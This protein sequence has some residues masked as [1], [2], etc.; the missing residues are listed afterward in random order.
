MENKKKKKNSHAFLIIIILVAA[1]L[2][3]LP[4]LISLRKQQSEI[5]EIRSAA[6]E[7]RTFTTSLSGAGTLTN[8]ESTAVMI[9]DGV[10]LTGYL[11]KN[12]DTI[13]A[14]TAVA[15]VDPVSV[16]D[17]ISDVKDALTELEEQIEEAQQDTET[18]TIT[19]ELDGRV[20]KLFVSAGSDVKDAMVDSGALVLISLDGLMAV[21]LSTDLDL[22][23]GDKVSVTVDGAAYEG[24]VETV[25]KGKATVTLTDDGPAYGSDAEVFTESGISIGTGKVYIHSCWKLSAYSGTVSSVYVSEGEEVEAD[26]SILDLEGVDTTAKYNVLTAEHRVYEEIMTELFALY[27]DNTVYADADGMVSGLD[28]DLL[29]SCRVEEPAADGAGNG[30]TLGM[31][32]GT[33]AGGTL[34]MSNDAAA[35]GTLGMSNDTTA[36]A[37]G[38]TVLLSL[39]PGGSDSSVYLHQ[40]GQVTEVGESGISL[41]LNPALQSVSDYSSLSGVDLSNMT[42]SVSYSL[43]GGVT[44]YMK[45]SAGEWQS[46]SDVTSFHTGDYVLFAYDTG[47]TSGASPLWIVDVTST[48]ADPTPTPTEPTPTPEGET[49]TPPAGDSGSTGQEDAEG[50]GGN[51]GG[52]MSGLPGGFDYSSLIGSATGGANTNMAALQAAMLSSGSYGDLSG[53]DTSSLSAMGMSDLSS[54]YTDSEAAAMEVANAL[55]NTEETSFMSIISLDQVEV[56]ITV[57]EQDILKL[58]KGQTAKI[59]LDA[60]PGRSFDAVITDIDT[61]GSNSGGNTKYTVTLTMDRTEEMLDGM[62]ASAVIEMETTEGSAAIPVAALS[63]ESGH[64]YVYTINEDDTLSGKTEVT[65]GVSDG[66]YV[67]ILEGIS[68]GTTVYY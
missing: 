41:V 57:D 52:N 24:T 58:E 3:L 16:T 45:N 14:G 20:K 27:Q 28:D 21:D 36:G 63:D 55:Y 44:A 29:V 4:T 48:I 65:T 56:D 18:A 40:V 32:D 50:Q 38:R 59:T 25:S 5:N 10:E 49:P 17:A 19:T 12:G 23:E 2:V 51:Q 11:V 43:S 39:T 68:N 9:P 47:D 53:Y 13:T 35:G 46:V 66:E 42:E 15:T 62:N 30:G 26:D 1:V 61:T 31:S 33:T 54:Y 22:K 8:N 67:E 7:D 37:A 64:T 34:G 6:A 60:L